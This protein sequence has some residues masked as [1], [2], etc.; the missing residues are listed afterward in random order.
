MKKEMFKDGT[1]VS[2]KKKAT[3]NINTF[4]AQNAFD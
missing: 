4:I 3:K 1:T 2:V